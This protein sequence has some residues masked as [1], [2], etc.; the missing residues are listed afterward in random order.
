MS[1]GRVLI[2]DSL[3]I[4]KEHEKLIT[5]AG[6]E[7]ERLD[8]PEPSEAELVKAIRGKSGYIL[9]GIEH[10]TEKVVEAADTLKAIVFTGID[11]KSY[12]PAW[13]KAT[14]RGIA[15]SNVPDGPTDAVSEWAIT[16]ALAMNRDIFSLG[17]LGDKKFH[18]TKGLKGQNIGLV[19]LGR[20]GSKIANMVRVFEPAS[21]AYFNRTRKQ[22][23]E[24][25]LDVEYKAINQLFSDSDV[26]FL[27]VPKSAGENYIS[28]EL[29][30]LMKKDALVVNITHPGVVDQ[31]ALLE[32]LKQGL[33]RAASDHPFTVKGYDD[34]PLSSWYC[35][36][37]SN[38]FNTTGSIKKTSDIATQSLINLLT[39]GKDDY[40]V[41]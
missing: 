40:K 13:E 41:N 29:V 35:F 10:V 7:I 19:G 20:I 22:D 31:E 39:T 27:C 37:G 34:L 24:S 38:A 11:Y 15:I 21:V 14:S 25:R 9:G 5:D 33:V 30:S 2:T 3:F 17:R 8:K 26:V 18:T 12:I 6:F 16:M 28:K 4:F 23:L 36:N 32:K 1:K